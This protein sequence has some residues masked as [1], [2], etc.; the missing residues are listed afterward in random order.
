MRDENLASRQI[1]N[2][3]KYFIICS[4]FLDH[5]T[6]KIHGARA[7]KKPFNRFRANLFISNLPF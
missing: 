4:L 5:F 7:S 1:F 2:I 6:P 3:F